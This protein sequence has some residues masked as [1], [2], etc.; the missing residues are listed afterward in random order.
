FSR[1]WSSD[2]CSSDLLLPLRRDHPPV[3]GLPRRPRLRFRRRG[4]GVRRRA[5]AHH[6]GR[7]GHRLDQVR[8]GLLMVT[9][10]GTQPRLPAAGRHLVRRFTYGHNGRLEADV[11]R[12]PS[13]SA[14]FEAQLA[15]GPDPAADATLAWLPR[16]KDSPAT[17]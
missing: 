12:F 5:V 1:D 10:P 4:P 9:V 3:D 7:L 8:R 2:V 6:P 17:A 16:L 11:L 13:V 14:W 15:P